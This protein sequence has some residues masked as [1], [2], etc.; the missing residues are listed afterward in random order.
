MVWEYFQRNGWIDFDAATETIGGFFAAGLTQLPPGT[1]AARAVADLMHLNAAEI[2]LPAA[3][4]QGRL[5]ADLVGVPF[6]L[7]VSPDA[8][9]LAINATDSG[10]FVGH[11]PLQARRFWDV[12]L[13]SSDASK[14]AWLA[15]TDKLE[16]LR[17]NFVQA[18]TDL[19]GLY[20]GVNQGFGYESLQAFRAAMPVV[21]TLW[22]AKL[23][24]LLQEDGFEGSLY[25]V[26]RAVASTN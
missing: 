2:D 4:A 20:R 22:R 15:K 13:Y 14:L 3:T 19:A 7:R 5:Q 24:V 23:A 21:M 16:G 11:D 18:V 12:T 17:E 1:P 6:H 10:P 26:Y 25:D 9:R 8:A